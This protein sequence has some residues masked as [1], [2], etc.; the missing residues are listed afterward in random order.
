MGVEGAPSHHCQ[1]DARAL[2]S[3]QKL[4]VGGRP[5]WATFLML[6]PGQTLSPFTSSPQGQGG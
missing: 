5:S 4:G 1:I 6:T 3:K 2:E